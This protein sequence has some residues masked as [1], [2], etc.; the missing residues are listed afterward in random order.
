MKRAILVL[1]AVVAFAAGTQVQAAPQSYDFSCAFIFGSYN[2]GDSDLF[3]GTLSYDTSLGTGSLA[4]DTS[5][6][7]WSGNGVVTQV[8]GNNYL[9]ASDIGLT[10]NLSSALHD[11]YFY[12]DRPGTVFGY[13]EGFGYASLT[14]AASVPEP[15]TLLLL[16]LGIGA[17]GFIKA[18]RRLLNK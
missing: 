7:D 2:F 3:S 9:Y 16:G 17:F 18:R 14:P 5:F 1:V 6:F 8:G 4:L 12:V 10:L 11:L 13:A 15:T